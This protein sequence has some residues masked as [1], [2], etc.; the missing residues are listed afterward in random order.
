VQEIA[1]LK[2]SLI[3]IATAFK[4]G[5]VTFLVGF[6]GFIVYKIVEIMA[7]R[8]HK[9]TQE[10]NIKMPGGQGQGQGA[11][12]VCPLHSGVESQ[13]EE[14]RGFRKEN[15]DAHEKIF[16]DIKGLSVSVAIAAASAAAAA[17]SAAFRTKE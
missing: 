4:L 11:A 17:S 12:K 15:H 3:N 14:L 6:L 8:Q 13:L 1:G 9:A 7:K 2:D 5:G 16:E 10:V